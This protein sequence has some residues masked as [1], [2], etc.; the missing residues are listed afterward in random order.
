MNTTVS[1]PPP[2]IAKTK[3]GR[4]HCASISCQHQ[5]TH[6]GRLQL[7]MVPHQ[8]IFLRIYGCLGPCI[9]A[10]ESQAGAAGEEFQ[11]SFPYSEMD[12]AARDNRGE[13]IRQIGTRKKYPVQQLGSGPF[14]PRPAHVL[15]SSC[16]IWT[17]LFQTFRFPAPIYLPFESRH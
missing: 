9:S 15:H 3:I 8:H 14:Q 2:R 17:N 11:F 10:R 5:S 16:R 4:S 12:D 1:T 7:F 13:S 6:F